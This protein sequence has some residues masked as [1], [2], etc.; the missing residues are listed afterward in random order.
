ML[1]VRAPDVDLGN[2]RVERD[3]R[4]SKVKQKV[5]GFFKVGIITG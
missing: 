4:M 1:F 2:N 3:L 5:S